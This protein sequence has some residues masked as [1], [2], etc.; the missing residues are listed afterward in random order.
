MPHFGVVIMNK[1]IAFDAAAQTEIAQQIRIYSISKL[2][3]STFEPLG[4]LSIIKIFEK[5][6]CDSY[7][8]TLAVKMNK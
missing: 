8:V 1:P 3:M 5:L 2:I 7:D 6:F 4:Y